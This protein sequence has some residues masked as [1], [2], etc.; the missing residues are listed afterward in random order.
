MGACA[1]PAELDLDLFVRWESDSRYYLMRIQFNLFGELELHRV[2]G[3]LGS[4][5]G[6]SLTEPVPDLDAGKMRF[7]QEERR[8]VSHGYLR[9]DRH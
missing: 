7:E 8:R 5:N 1:V 6:G 4:R 2:W 3:G 9:V